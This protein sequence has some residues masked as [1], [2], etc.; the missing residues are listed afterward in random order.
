MTYVGLQCHIDQRFYLISLY[1]PAILIVFYR[2]TPLAS[3]LSRLPSLLVVM[4]SIP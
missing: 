2:P 1:W 3:M 4:Y